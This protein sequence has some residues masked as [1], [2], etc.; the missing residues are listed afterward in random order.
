MLLGAATLLAFGWAAQ[1]QDVAY[2]CATRAG[3]TYTDRLCAGARPVGSGARSRTD[4]AK[5]VPQDRARIAR[6]ARL[7][8]EQRQEC[9]ALDLQLAE[10]Q[11]AFK[12]IGTAATLQ[13]EM[14]MVH[15]RKRLRELR[16]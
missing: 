4:K 10:Q 11:R 14:P 8:P 1:A 6:R 5:P 12:A 9:S 3:V 16:C 2:R 7:T 15:T 13:D